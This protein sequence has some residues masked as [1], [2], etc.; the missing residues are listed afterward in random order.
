M[1]YCNFRNELSNVLVQFRFYVK[2][3]ATKPYCPSTVPPLVHFSVEDL[4]TDSNQVGTLANIEICN[5][6]IC[7]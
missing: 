2:P 1:K 4:T 5:I 3:D 7:S 6:N